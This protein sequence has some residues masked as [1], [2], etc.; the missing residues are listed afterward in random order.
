M[1]HLAVDISILSSP[2]LKTNFNFN[3]SNSRPISRIGRNSIIL[4]SNQAIVPSTLSHPPFTHTASFLLLHSQ[5]SW[6]LLYQ[7]RSRSANIHYAL[8]RA[9]CFATR[10]S[11]DLWTDLGHPLRGTGLSPPTISPVLG[12]EDDEDTRGSIG[13]SF[14]L[15]MCIRASSVPLGER[16][17]YLP[18]NWEGGQFR[19]GIILSFRT[20]ILF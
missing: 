8:V 16:R 9:V 10:V 19:I 13:T 12:A 7:L 15:D 17:D 11:L 1:W 4:I 14:T 6:I 18:G 5:E 3:P 2:I 20:L